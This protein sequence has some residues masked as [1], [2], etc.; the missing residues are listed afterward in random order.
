[1]LF[2]FQILTECIRIRMI[3]GFGKSCTYDYEN[4]RFW[5]INWIQIV[6]DLKISAEYK[7]PYLV[8][9]IWI[10][11]YLLTP[12]PKS[13]LFT[14]FWGLRTPL[15]FGDSFASLKHP[16]AQALAPLPPPGSPSASETFQKLLLPLYE[17]CR[18]QMSGDTFTIHNKVLQRFLSDVWE[19]RSTP[20]SPARMQYKTPTGAL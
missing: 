20:T 13:T 6:F 9:T 7:Y 10:P 8:S 16:T 15:I 5:K 12:H 2:G 3:F 4:N 17:G 11:N 1:M 18:P 19:Y 14:F